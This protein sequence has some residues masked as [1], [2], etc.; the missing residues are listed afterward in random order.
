MGKYVHIQR[1]R[2]HGILD[3]N[4]GMVSDLW[5]RDKS[6]SRHVIRPFEEFADGGYVRSNRNAIPSRPDREVEACIVAHYGK[7]GYDLINN[8]CEHYVNKCMYGITQSYQ[9]NTIAGLLVF[10]A[11]IGLALYDV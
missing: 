10:G 6:N 8:N 9:V 4:T 11:I 7:G 1:G 2:H 5:G 3:P